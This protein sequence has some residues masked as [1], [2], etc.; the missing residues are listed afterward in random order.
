MRGDKRRRLSKIEDVQAAEFESE[1]E[2]WLASLSEDQREFFLTG[3]L[4]RLAKDGLAPE[5]AGA[6]SDLSSE[7]DLFALAGKM[8]KRDPALAARHHSAAILATVNTW[9][10]TWP[11]IERWLR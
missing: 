5:L 10:S 2:H 3:L 9:P 11:G 6:L 7:D 1:R 8:Q 4:T